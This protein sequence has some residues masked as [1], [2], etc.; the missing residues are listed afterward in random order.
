MQIDIRRTTTPRTLPQGPLGFGKHF[1][2]HVFRM[3]YG[4]PQGHGWHSPRIEPYGPLPVDPAASVL[5]YGQTIFE[6]LKAFKGQDGRVQLF[7]PDRHAQRFADSARRLCMPVLE[8]ADFVQAVRSLVSVERAWV[9]AVEGGA[10]Y[11]RPILFGTE[12]FLGV[13]PATQYTFYVILSPVGAYYA[14]GFNPVR[15]WCERQ[16]IRAAPG[17]LGSAKTAA[18]YVASMAAA[19]S[20]RARGYDQVLW[21]DAIEHRYLEEVGTMNVFAVFDDEVA[22][23]ALGDTV[24]PG[25]TRETVLQ[26]LKARGLRATERKVSVEELRQAHAKGTLREVFGTGTAAVVSPVGVLGTD[27]G[28]LVIG[29][30][31]AGP[32]AL[33]LFDEIT[34]IQRGVTEDR[35]GWTLAVD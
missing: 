11:V 12:A 16:H 26:L 18:N 30:G 19:E 14:N 5:H 15:I 8:P 23:P 9:P 33:G 34:K 31:K 22:T 13:R 1:T 29:G 17:G 3:D 6:G 24:L 4:G 28:E 27:E 21:L 20:A 10:L 7:R 2:D 35:W 25:V 32:L